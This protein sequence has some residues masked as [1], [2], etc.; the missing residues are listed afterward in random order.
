M[1]G[2]EEGRSKGRERQKFEKIRGGSHFPARTPHLTSVPG[3]S[4]KESFRYRG[5]GVKIW[6]VDG[7]GVGGA[8]FRT[9]PV[10][11]DGWEAKN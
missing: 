3:A 8:P 7:C 11:R 9:H 6:K 5:L 4:A 2:D 1:R 10:G